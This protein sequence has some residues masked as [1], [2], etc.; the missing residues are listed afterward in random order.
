MDFFQNLRIYTIKVEDT[1]NNDLV[2]V[3]WCEIIVKSRIKIQTSRIK[4][5]TSRIKIQTQTKT[6]QICFNMS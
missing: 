5:Q 1:K 2:E 4:I 3:S 6:P